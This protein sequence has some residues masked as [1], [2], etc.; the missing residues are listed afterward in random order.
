V[1]AAS[2]EKNM[3]TFSQ[4]VDGWHD[5]YILIGTA[6]ATLV[7]LL[8]VSLSLNAD[9]I[10]RKTNIDLR[11]L[12][13]QTFTSFICVLM[14]AVIFLIPRQGPQGLG[15]PLVGIDCIGLYT[16]ARRFVEMRRNRSRTWGKGRLTR[17]FVIPALCF[18]TL[19]IIAVLVLLGRTGGLYW[20][21]PVMIMLIWGASL[22]AWDLLLRLREPPQE[23]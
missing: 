8:F 11:V 18:M 9:V 22:N 2:R 14:F 6:A 19:M 23:S 16:T 5:F 10:I 17:R 1:C 4:V 21:V 3:A 15:L 7:G 12:A 20:L 13:A